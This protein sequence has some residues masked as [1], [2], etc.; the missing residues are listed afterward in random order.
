MTRSCLHAL[1]FAALVC[2]AQTA[3]AV[4]I[5]DST[6][7]AEGGSKRAPADGF[8][9]AKALAHQPQFAATI[10]FAENDGEPNWGECSG[11]WIGN[12]EAAGVAYVLTAAHCFPEGGSASDYL[13]R[14]TGG[15]V[16]EGSE[17]I[18]H[19]EYVDVSST[20]GFDVAIVVL[21]GT[22]ED[23]DQPATIY[24]GHDEAGQLLTFMGYGS[25]GIGS[26]GQQDRYYDGDG[27]KA[28][29]TGV[30]D[31]LQDGASDEDSGDYLGVVLLREDG[32][33]ENPYGGESTPHDRYAGL[34]GSGDSGGSA[35]I[36]VG[37]RWLLAGVNSNGTGEAQYG[38]SSWFVR[39]SA[40]RDWIA[41]TAPVA[42]FGQ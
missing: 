1:S 20:T 29:A 31:Y 42:R 32:S 33:V 7:A 38:D 12:D 4:I 27:E 18:I 39:L 26:A 28:A 16:F 3:S 21:D 25:R 6:W 9:A 24:A 34:L 22:I 35:F 40:R 37:R 2:A 41:E 36:Q 13:Y 8:E 15:S 10:A 5:L 19:P 14:S 11:T 17:L 30:V 23:V